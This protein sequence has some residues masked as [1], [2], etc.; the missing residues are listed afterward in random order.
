MLSS[1]SDFSS[2]HSQ[3]EGYAGHLALPYMQLLYIIP[4]RDTVVA[5]LLVV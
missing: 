1:D 4:T 5:E 2:L 3:L